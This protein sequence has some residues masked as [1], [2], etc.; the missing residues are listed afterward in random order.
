MRL[1]DV[2][3]FQF[4]ER[5]SNEA[6]AILSHT[7]DTQELTYQDMITY[8][9]ILPPSSGLNLS[10]PG[11]IKV[12]GAC[13]VA[14]AL[15]LQYMWID[16]CCINKENPSEL[17]R[18]VRS[19]YRWYEQAATCIVY[20]SD[21]SST[22]SFGISFTYKDLVFKKVLQ[23]PKWFTRGWTL[24]ELVAPHELL[25]YDKAWK[26]IGTKLE[27]STQISEATKI[28]VDV[29]Q[30]TYP[31]YR[32]SAAQRLSWA[33]ERKTT[34]EE[35]IA[36]SLIGIFDVTLQLDYGEGYSSPSK[37]S[38]RYFCETVDWRKTRNSETMRYV[39]FVSSVEENGQTYTIGVCLTKIS[40]KE[41]KRDF[42]APIV[43][44]KA[45]STMF[46]ELGEYY[47]SIRDP[48]HALREV[49]RVL[50][51]SYDQGLTI[52]T[53]WRPRICIEAQRLEIEDIWPPSRWDHVQNQLLEPASRLHIS[54]IWVTAKFPTENLQLVILYDHRNQITEARRVL[55]ISPT[56]HSPIF[57]KLHKTK[58]SHRQDEQTWEELETLVPSVR[59]HR[60]I[61][62]YQGAPKQVVWSFDAKNNLTFN[63]KA[64]PVA[65]QDITSDGKRINPSASSMPQ[66]P[67]F[68]AVN[69]ATSVTNHRS[70]L[71]K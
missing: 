43:K 49:P 21:F 40:E 28:P 70:F 9:R 11:A 14:K 67:S 19:M 41:F 51:L 66:S 1:L 18:A 5:D 15:G 32:C 54:W 27:L 8:Q 69:N 58:P 61:V 52:E 24:Q 33:A 35:D 23:S 39:V 4:K 26:C 63:L 48:Y 36:Y 29:L 38:T 59:K 22:S 71:K 68:S 25:F 44:I 53:V 50:S 45:A 13:S 10:R 16:T 34:E 62:T 57:N 42:L 46:V 3:T 6:Y 37:Q 31:L 60:N 55:F 30:K 47:I 17:A 65:P 12:R 2:D 7:W 56:Q 64:L 20:L